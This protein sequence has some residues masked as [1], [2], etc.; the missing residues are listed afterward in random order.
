M[1]QMPDG[2]NRAAVPL[3]KLRISEDNYVFTD[4]TAD[5]LQKAPGIPRVTVRNRSSS[6]GNARP[7]VDL[8]LNSPAPKLR[9]LGKSHTAAGPPPSPFRP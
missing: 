7:G 9:G 4:M 5:Q 8:I 1:T 6:V 2:E 3:D